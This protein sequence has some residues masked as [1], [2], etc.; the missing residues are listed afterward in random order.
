MCHDC[1]KRVFE[2]SITDPTTMPPKCCEPD[3]PIEPTAAMKKLFTHSFKQKWNLKYEEAT[4]KYKIYC[5]RKRCGQ[6]IRHKYIYTLPAARGDQGP[7]R[8]YGQCS[9]CGTRVCVTCSAKFH[10]SRECPKDPATLAFQKVAE[11]K[12]WQQCYNCKA[13]IE[14]NKGC[15]HM[16]CRC[17][18][19][20]CILCG[21]KWKT[22]DCPMFEDEAIQ[23]DHERVMREGAGM[24]QGGWFFEDDDDDGVGMGMGMGGNMGGW[25]DEWAGMQANEA[26]RDV[27]RHI[28]VNRHH[29]P[30]FGTFDFGRIQ[31]ETEALGRRMER[32]MHIHEELDY[33]LTSS[34]PE[35]DRDLIFLNGGP[36]RRDLAA[37]RTTHRDEPPR[38]NT[39]REE[40]RRRDHDGG[41]P[42]T[43]RGG[44]G[45]S[46]DGGYHGNFGGQGR[47]LDEGYNGGG[48]GGGGR[49]YNGGRMRMRT[50]SPPLNPHLGDDVLRRGHDILTR[51]Y[52]DQNDRDAGI[53]VEEINN[54]RSAANRRP[55][56]ANAPPLRRASTLA[57]IGTGV[58]SRARRAGNGGGLNGR[59]SEWRRYVD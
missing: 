39:T 57:G 4:A 53:L 59:V 5:P 50:A 22:C 33:D 41:G 20:F 26:A 27:E 32:E 55:G 35:S 58:A 24:P 21:E 30:D 36:G 3:F 7:K 16:T 25:D 42:P 43:L 47:R 9:K 38:R 19:E 1:I 12:G 23:E 17:H 54:G 14:H 44:V 10:T 48:G 8:R 13:M 51:P 2:L 37:R 45:R 52:N 11:E 29:V 15:N 6:F 56:R 46:R 28:Y 34:D 18:A 31:A 49:R 40:P